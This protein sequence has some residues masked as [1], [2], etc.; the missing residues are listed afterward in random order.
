[1]HTGGRALIELFKLRKLILFS[2][3]RSSTRAIMTGLMQAR[4]LTGPADRA[5]E[6]TDRQLLGIACEPE[7]QQLM[8]QPSSERIRASGSDCAAVKG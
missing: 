3:A 8:I 4:L 2:H 7:C 1:M 6:V 5:T